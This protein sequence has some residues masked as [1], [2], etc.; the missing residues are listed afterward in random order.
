MNKKYL[1][2]TTI[3]ILFISLIWLFGFSNKN[4][5]VPDE[6]IS[7]EQSN[8][9]SILNKEELGTST[10]ISNSHSF[11][12]LTFPQNTYDTSDWKTYRNEEY[13]F[14]IKYPSEW[15]VDFT[16]TTNNTP[17]GTTGN[18]FSEGGYGGQLI[19]V[20]KNNSEIV[21][22]RVSNKSLETQINEV[23]NNEIY[24]N[25]AIKRYVRISS[26]YGFETN[27]FEGPGFHVYERYVLGGKNNITYEFGWLNEPNSSGYVQE[28][29]KIL[30]SFHTVN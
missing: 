22:L 26:A 4:K 23:N 12:E 21:F 24:K 10:Q 28:M 3:C 2:L 1:S 16:D 6:S 11:E 20:P 27:N 17:L 5:S 25:G 13:G 19:F 15:R 14:E 7:I 8:T 18:G 30:L 9:S 29:E